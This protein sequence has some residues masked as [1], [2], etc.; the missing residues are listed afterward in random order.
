MNKKPDKNAKKQAQQAYELRKKKL[1]QDKDKYDGKKFKKQYKNHLLWTPVT[2]L[3]QPTKRPTK[4]QFDKMNQYMW[5]RPSFGD[6]PQQ[7]YNKLRDPKQK[8][9]KYA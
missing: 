3:S 6:T 2:D 5:E 7:V 1:K 9:V 8:T 4:K